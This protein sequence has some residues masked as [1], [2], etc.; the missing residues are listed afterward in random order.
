MG[1]GV[2]V[3]AGSAL[4]TPEATSAPSAALGPASSCSAELG[5]GGLPSTLGGSCSSQEVLLRVLSVE[6]GPC[7]HVLRCCPQSSPGPPAPNSG[8]IAEGWGDA[9]RSERPQKVG[10][11]EALWSA[12]W[13]QAPQLS[14]L[15]QVPCLGG[16]QPPLL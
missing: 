12:D 7:A 16:P 10:G 5:S 9:L 13:L 3:V 14:D 2:G 4:R 15:S 11:G 8:A 6:R 1:V